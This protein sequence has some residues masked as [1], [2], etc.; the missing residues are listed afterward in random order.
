[1]RRRR[2]PVPVP[3]PRPARRLGTTAAAAE[4][5]RL[6]NPATCPLS[7]ADGHVCGCLNPAGPVG[8]SGLVSV[9]SSDAAV[10]R[11]LVLLLEAEGLTARAFCALPSFLGIMDRPQAARRHCLVIEEEQARGIDPKAL[12]ARVGHGA[13][14]VSIVVLTGA[15]PPVA[16]P[17]G[18]VAFVDPFGVDDVLRTIRSALGAP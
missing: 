7:S 10:R 8:G 1:M 4:E 6:A 2:L 3:P 18:G 14:E 17:E 12:A 11:A 13:G 15:R 16:M 5:V 9:I